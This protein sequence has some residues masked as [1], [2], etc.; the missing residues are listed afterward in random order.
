[1]RVQCNVGWNGIERELLSVEGG[2]LNMVVISYRRY[3]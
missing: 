1:M 2:I 3:N